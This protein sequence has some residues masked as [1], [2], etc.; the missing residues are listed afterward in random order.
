MFKLAGIV[1]IS[2][3]VV[4]IA[5]LGFTFYMALTVFQSYFPFRPPGADLTSTLNLLLGAAIQ[6]M[7]LGVMGWVGSILLVRGVDFLKVEKGVGVVTFKVE[8]GVGVVTN[9]EQEKK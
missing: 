9:V 4:G 2:T 8:K 7:F 5:L 1:G 3:T 6:A